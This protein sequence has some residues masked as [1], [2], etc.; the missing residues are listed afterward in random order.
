MAGN[1]ITSRPPISLRRRPI[2]TLLVPLLAAALFVRLGVWQLARLAERRAFNATLLARREAPPVP[3][4]ALGADTAAG[5]YRRASATGVFLYDRELAYAG[6][7]HE[8]SPGVNLLT[9]LRAAGTDTV[10]MVNRGWVYSPDAATVAFAKWR[11][12]DS[13]AVA[14]FAETFA[15]TGRG[16]PPS[17]APKAER[18]SRSGAVYRLNRADVE[19]AVGL[20]VAPFI[21]VQTSDSATRGDSVPVRLVLPSLDEGPHGS[22]A[23]QWFSFAT[24]AVVGGAVLFL[25]RRDA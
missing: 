10:V 6:R 16:A 2:L 17:G 1:E 24:I 14:G 20:P 15:A 21:L 5:H 4:G 7:T 22:Y 9:P 18:G 11:E 13:V 8:G 19:R 23:M 25:K 3:V 12:R